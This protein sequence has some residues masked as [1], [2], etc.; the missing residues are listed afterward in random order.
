MLLAAV[1]YYITMA[2]PPASPGQPIIAKTRL[3]I[4]KL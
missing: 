2:A 3:Q 4:L 1:A